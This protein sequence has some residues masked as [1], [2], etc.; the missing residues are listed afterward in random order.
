[1]IYPKLLSS[2]NL[3]EEKVF[4]IYL[5]SGIRPKQEANSIQLLFTN[6]NTIPREILYIATRINN[7]FETTEKVAKR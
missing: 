4:K 2:L 6:K 1:M 7:L 3:E 5:E